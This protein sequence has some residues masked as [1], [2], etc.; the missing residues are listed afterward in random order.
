[1][2]KTHQQNTKNILQFVITSFLKTIDSKFNIWFN[3]KHF[4]NLI[5]L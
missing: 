3:K 2:K 1:M 4:L 5:L